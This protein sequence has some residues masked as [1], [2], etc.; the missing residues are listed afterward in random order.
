MD[1]AKK[2]RSSVGTSSSPSL[3]SEDFQKAFDFLI[4][5]NSPSPNSGES[6]LQRLPFSNGD[7]TAGSEN[8]YQTAV[9]GAKENVDLAM[10]FENSN[11]FK[12]IVKGGTFELSPKRLA[13]ELRHF[14]DQP[15]QS[16]WE[17]SWVRFPRRLLSH[18]ADQVLLH[19]LLADKK[20]PTSPY[21]SDTHKFLFQQDG[22]DWLRIP[23]SYLLRITLA[24]S[25]STNPSSPYLIR[26]IGE[27]LMSHFLN[28]N[29][30]PE[31][32]SFYVV[33]V[34][35]ETGMGRGVGREASKRFLLS[36]LLIEYANHKFG[37][38]DSG[39]EAM[40]YFAPHPPIR[41]K[42]LNGLISDSFYRELFMNPCLSGW[43]SGEDKHQ[44]M[45]LCHEVLSRSHLN[46]VASLKD[47]G[48][49][50]RNLVTLPS[51]SNISLANNGTHVSLGSRK[52]SALLKQHDSPFSPAC[53]K[54]VGDLVI[55]I[56]EHFLPLFVGTYSA[57]PYR[58]DFWDFHPEQAL[59]FLPHELQD[60]HL[61]LVWQ[62]WKRKAGLKIL[63]Q[64]FTPIGPLW[65]DKLIS[66]VFGLKGDFI[67]DF[68]L[69][70][71]LAVLPSTEQSP[72]LDGTLGNGERLKKDLTELGIYDDRMSL[73]LL[74]KLRACSEMG[75]SG[76]EG[77][78][79]SLFESL[80]EDMADAASLQAL[81]TALAF[82]Y[83]FQYQITH[84]HIPDTLTVESERRQIFFGAA[85]NLPT[86]YV[87]GD[88][89]NLFLG[90]IL[91]KTKHI[92]MSHRFS[93]FVRVHH[94]AYRR[95][96]LS[97]IQ[98]DGGDLIEAFGLEEC[99]IRLKA[100][101]D[102][103][104]EYSAF[105]KLTQGILEESGAS[106]P[107]RLDGEEWNAAAET[108]YRKTLRRKHLQEGFAFLNED[109]QNRKKFKNIQSI[110]GQSVLNTIL[111]RN[112]H[113]KS[114]LQSVEPEILEGRA[115]L[116]GIMRLIQLVLLSL[117][118]DM[119]C[120]ETS[121]RDSP[122]DETPCAS[123]H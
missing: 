81:I 71:Y 82:K 99:L 90:K 51:P 25:I 106:S 68:R 64:P 78:Y 20:N 122:V 88:S 47:A 89:K 45:N 95:A 5:F 27:R 15:E 16:V 76:F 74:Y 109:F 40:I 33:N 79:Y 77:R 18:F 39:Q 67:P 65:I 10:T 93:R 119:E 14:L 12:N 8:E 58:M 69:I 92:R 84:A 75:F 102:D 41:Q 1:Y 23:I 70:D 7:I 43:N 11:F 56:V 52:L 57:A 38:K 62:R 120:S 108:Y 42:K 55:K 72:A 6:F 86:F 44:Y 35:P 21:R 49:I 46:A 30:S 24:D 48:I 63:G 101:L 22:E 104:E 34:N 37:L 73:Y 98:E 4:G 60:I 61:K 3:S 112:V 103:P 66:R 13:K 50:T 26:Q 113:P 96:L 80:S 110:D 116:T 111:E 97:I 94:K 91:A 118:P 9:I 83:I 87:Q 121:I 59:G 100:K 115:N 19:D 117:Y 53:E 36:N 123:I 105:G 29:T 114:F 107:L 31:T 28:D 85:L 2:T 54:Y 32:F 17:N